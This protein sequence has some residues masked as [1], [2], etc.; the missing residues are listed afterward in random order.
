MIRIFADSEVLSHAAAE[1]FTTTAR[2]AVKAHGRFAVALAGG[3]TPRRTY[4][5]LAELPFREQVPWQNVHV[6]WE[7][8]RCVPADDPRNNSLM[9]RRALLDH[10]PLPATQI[11]PIACGD[12]PQ[13]RAA[14]YERLLRNFFASGSSRFDLVF[15]GLGE[16]GHTASLFPGS[17]A[18]AEEAHWT[19]V[20]ARR[21]EEFSRVTLTFPCL[22]RAAQVVFLVAGVAKARILHALLAKTPEFAPLP[23]RLIQPTDGEL[24]WLVDRSAAGLIRDQLIV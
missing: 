13:R 6:F 14:G 20:T 15:L 24:V 7:D 10:V 21:G 16:D 17:A 8:E 9:A 3:E 12:D 22:N 1:L 19:A 11:H 4:E 2:R 23:A 5:I 18:L